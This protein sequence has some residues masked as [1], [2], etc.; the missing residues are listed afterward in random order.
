[1]SGTELC[2]KD[3]DEQD[4]PWPQGS[5]GVVGKT[6]ISVANG[7]QDV[8]GIM[9]QAAVWARRTVGRECRKSFWRK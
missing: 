6:E 4:C 7:T 8:V 1:M 2:I 5:S 9:V 3:S